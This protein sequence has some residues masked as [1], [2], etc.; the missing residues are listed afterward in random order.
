MQDIKTGTFKRAYLLHG[1]EDYL[2]LLWRGRLLDALVPDKSSMNYTAWEGEN[3]SEGAVIDQAETLPFFSDRRV[4]RLDHT[5]LFERPAE[6]LAEYMKQLPEYLVII[7]TENSVDKRNRLFKAVQKYGHAAEFPAQTEET[8][9][10]WILQQL[11]R[12]NLRIRKSDM[13]LLLTKTGTDMTRISQEVDKLIHYSAGSGEVTRQDI[14][15]VT[16]SRL[17]NRIFDMV[18]AVS[19]KQAGKAM[20]LYADLLALKESPMRVLYLIVRQYDQLLAMRELDLEGAGQQ[21]IAKELGLPP[22]VVRK[23][24][25]LARKYNSTALTE[26]LSFCAEM[27]EDVKSGR[28][29]DH[30][31]VELA[32]VKL[33]ML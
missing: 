27:E 14:E 33:A 28:M 13:E 3:I 25:P 30:L 32:I 26:A 20:I 23:M 21:Q 12:E 4:I 29:T 9:T 7:F 16:T 6:Q 31:A 8:L 19:Q 5:G 18:N 22:F 11:S 17:E 15:L 10:K 24:L 2:K 1:P